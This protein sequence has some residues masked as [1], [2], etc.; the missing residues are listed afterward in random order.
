M[1]DLKTGRY[2]EFV[3]GGAF[4]PRVPSTSNEHRQNRSSTPTIH[5]LGQFKFS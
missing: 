1:I 5:L 2:P 4:A 3:S